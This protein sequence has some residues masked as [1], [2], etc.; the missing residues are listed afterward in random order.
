MPRDAPFFLVASY[1]NPHNICEWGRG[2][3]GALPDGKLD[4]PPPIEKC[5]PLKHNHLPENDETE[6]I[7]L[8]RRSYQASTTFPVGDFGEREWREYL[9]AYYRMVE[10]V[11]EKIGRLLSSLETA[12]QKG[13]TVILFLSDHGDAQ[14]AHCWNQKTVFYDESSRVPF[15]VSHPE[16]AGSSLSSQIVQTG[17]DLIPTLCDIAG[18]GI[19]SELPGISALDVTLGRG[20]TAERDWIVCETQF[21]Q[22]AAIDG[23][24]PHVDGR[25][26][27]SERFK[28]CIYNRGGHRESLVDM[29]HDPGETLNLARNTDYFN[30]L[31]QHRA[32]LQE[33]CSKASDTFPSIDTRQCHSADS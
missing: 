21:V 14:G 16:R 15:I 23:M 12:G 29:E 9:W 5:P 22:G 1:N 10:I 3:R 20:R 30:I 4:S 27:R 6:A 32:Y 19:P 2:E 26:V 8:L 31:K 25:M 11:D 33:Y 24:I 7:T 18:I 28:Y 13:N 17:I